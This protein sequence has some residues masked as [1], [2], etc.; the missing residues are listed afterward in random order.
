MYKDLAATWEEV[1]VGVEEHY[2][3]PDGESPFAAPV[4]VV[5]TPEEQK[6]IDLRATESLGSI[7]RKLED[8]IDFIENST[9]LPVE[10]KSWMSD[11]KTI[12]G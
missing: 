9:P 2:V 5:I 7:A 10:T 6:I 12:R 11:R 3:R 1:D 8:V 4:A